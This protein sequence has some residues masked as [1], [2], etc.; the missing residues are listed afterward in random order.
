MRKFEC[1]CSYLC[2]VG[3]LKAEKMEIALIQQLIEEVF[4]DFERFFAEGGWK[5]V[6]NKSNR[7]KLQEYL[8]LKLGKL[9]GRH[10]AYGSLDN[11]VLSFFYT[12]NYFKTCNYEIKLFSEFLMAQAD[13]DFLFLF[14][15]LRRRSR[16]HQR[17]LVVRS[18][19]IA[20]V[21]A[22]L[23]SEQQSPAHGVSVFA[24]ENDGLGEVKLLLI[25][26]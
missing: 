9:F 18:E 5:A 16:R 13:L 8:L 22:V 1:V 17:D 11:F 15:V 3:A 2:F 19:H 20:A 12:L 6:K 4:D 23:K 14:V 10:R 26:P 24:A 7:C 25:F 21:V